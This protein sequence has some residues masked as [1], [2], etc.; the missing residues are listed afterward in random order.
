VKSIRWQLTMSLLLSLWL[1]IAISDGLLYV[2]TEKSLT[3]EFDVA[4][5]A[6]ANA[7]SALATHDAKGSV[8]L[9]F[10][11]EMMPAFARSKNPDYFEFWYKDGR[12]FARSRSLRQ[13]HLKRPENPPNGAKVANLTLSDGRWGRA[14]WLVFRPAKDP[15]VAPEP[16][17]QPS[18][19]HSA[20]QLTLM[21]AQH[22]DSLDHILNKM[23]WLIAGTG[24]LLPLLVAVIVLLT[25]KR[26]LRPLERLARET[27]AID[28][29]NL[30]YRFDE[31]RMPGELQPIGRRLNALIE[32]LEISFKQVQETCERE[33]R[34]ND[35]VAHELR[36]PIAELR[37]L[38]EVALMFPDDREMGQKARQETLDISFQMERLVSALLMMA[39]CEAG[40]ESLNVE[41][42]DLGEL[43]ARTWG[44]YRERALRRGIHFTQE[45]P[46]NARGQADLT[47]FNS[48]MNNLI[49]NSVDYCPEKG[50]IRITAKEAEDGLE[51]RVANT[52][53]SLI[54]DDLAWICEP[55]WRKENSRASSSHSGLGLSLAK[56]ICRLM[57]IE[58]S[59]SLNNGD[60]IVELRLPH[61][62][63]ES[64]DALS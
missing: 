15:D 5:F 49:S 54:E 27:E 47:L 35:N 41:P 8:E 18:Q 25:V 11:D 12:T 21:L 55:F 6:K 58:L 45:I 13:N 50:A 43:V 9:E 20:P 16:N 60:F 52:N 44:H 3:R 61:A 62:P 28:S 37:A 10:S 59:A 22:R 1:L 33:R 51:L 7:L 57:S 17:G 23:L 48:V 34:F 14:V 56:S 39:R 53:D 36:T 63:S 24:I 38:S 30:G 42:V 64:G 46:S 2:M 31:T 29:Q 26:G 19:A 40:I 32:R 4:L